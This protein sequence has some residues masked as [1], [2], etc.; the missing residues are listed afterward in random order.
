MIFSW[1]TSAKRNAPMP[2]GLPASEQLAYQSIAALVARYRMGAVSV[3]QAQKERKQIDQRSLIDSA[4]E[5][6]IKWTVDLRRRID[7]AQSR[8][9]KERTDEAADLLSD[10]LDG[11]VRI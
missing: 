3:E 2:A 9:R 1:E 10:V 11:F 8:Y 5:G 4:N 6:S 7:I